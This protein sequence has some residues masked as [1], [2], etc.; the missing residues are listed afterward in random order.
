MTNSEI[1]KMESAVRAEL[2]KS[3]EVFKDTEGLYCYEIYADYNDAMDA[4]TATEILESADPEQAFAEKMEEWYLNY[5]VGAYYELENSIKSKL[6][7]DGGPYPKCFTEEENNMFVDL[8]DELVYVKLPEDHFLDQEFCVNIMVDSG[9]G[10]YDYTLNSVYPCWY[11][12]YE[13]RLDDKAGIVWLARQQGYTKTQL[14]KA[15][16]EGD[17]ADPHS[18]LETMRQEIANCASHTM[19]LTFLVKMRLRDL[20]E[21]NRL[22]KLQDRNGHFYDATKNPDCGYIVIDKKT[23]TGL[24]N[25]WGGGGSVLEIELDKDVRLPIRFIRSALPDGGDGYSIESVY[26]MCGSAWTQGEV[27]QIYC[28]KK[29]RKA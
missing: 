10:N 15:L 14:W 4:D 26:G 28:P 5:E 11:G 13:Q 1:A 23:M 8:V 20:M 21:L 24:Y 19:T 27:K 7:T 18:F 22:I 16:R 12:R 9:D 29:L 25:P 2:D 3:F 17:I 6:T